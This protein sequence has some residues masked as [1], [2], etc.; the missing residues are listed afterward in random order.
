MRIEKKTFES[1]LLINIYFDSRDCSSSPTRPPGHS[2]SEAF[3]ETVEEATQSLYPLIGE[4]GMDW[5]YSNCSTTAQRGAL[6]WWRPF[7]DAAKPVFED[8][9]AKVVEGTETARSLDKNSQPNYREELE[10]ELAEIKESEIWR[11]GTFLISRSIVGGNCMILLMCICK[12]L[13]NL[14]TNT[15][16]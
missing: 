10:K 9:Y 5:M 2:P 3:N 11:A 12:L 1:L 13:Y 14:L 7:H 6:D 16:N 4:K 8:L 15:C